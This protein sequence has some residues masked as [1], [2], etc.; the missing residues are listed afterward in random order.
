MSIIPLPRHPDRTNILAPLS[1]DRRDEPPPGRRLARVIA[2]IERCIEQGWHSGAQI[3]ASVDGD[4]WADLA[5]DEARP[6]VQMTTSTIVE[7][8]SATKPITCVAAG[9]LWQ[10]G[11]LDLDHPVHRHLPEFAAA[12]K[13]AVTVRHLLTHTAGLTSTVTDIAPARDLVADICAAP[14]APGWV[15]GERCAY[16]SV[17]MWIVAELVSRIDGRPFDL[18]VRQEIFEPAGMD[19]SWIG[20]PLETYRAVQNRI[21]IIPGSA[22]SG[23]EEWVT[24]GRP[25]GGGHG[26]IAQLGRFYQALLDGRILIATTLAAM[27]S[28]QLTNVYDEYLGA[29]VDRGL[30]FALGSS[31]PAHGYGDHASPRA[32][33]HGGRTWSVAFADPAHDLA[34]AVYWNGAADPATHTQRLPSLLNALYLDLEIAG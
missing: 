18:F 9:I 22:R 21:A 15:P 30:G 19:E 11:L 32:F 23:T 27:S 7:W 34:A 14:L 20:M 3:Y 29:T 31:N 13:T 33:G 5:I 17:A 16:N 26:P 28:R 10:R 1:Y 6:A 24:W 25:T 12:G 4:V 2:E 8:A